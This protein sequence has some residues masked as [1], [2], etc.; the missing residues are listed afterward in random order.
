MTVPAVPLYGRMPKD[1]VD[2]IAAQKA[3]NVIMK[4]RLKALSKTKKVK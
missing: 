1:L 4:Q 3:L 2:L